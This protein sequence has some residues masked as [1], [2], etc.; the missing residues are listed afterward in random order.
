MVDTVSKEKRSWIMSRIKGKNTKPEILVRR[1]LHRMGYRFRLNSPNLL[2]HPDIILKKY[3]TI[4][5]V[6]G[7]FWHGHENC[8]KASIPKSNSNFWINKIKKNRTRD[9]KNQKALKKSGWNV[10][11]IWECEI[12][13]T[14]ILRKKIK[15]KLIIR[16]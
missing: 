3:K 9:Q 1:L 12:A 7:C 16:G 11:V 2:G 13:K 10:F 6:N 8:R 15:R 14:D 5:F 4:I